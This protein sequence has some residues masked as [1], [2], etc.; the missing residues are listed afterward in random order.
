M[1]LVSAPSTSAFLAVVDNSLIALNVTLEVVQAVSEDTSDGLGKAELIAKVVAISLAGASNMSPQTE[2]K[3]ICKTAELIARISHVS[4][5]TVRLI[6][7]DDTSFRSWEIFAANVFGIFRTS[8]NLGQLGEQKLIEKL[9]KDPNATRPVYECHGEDIVY[10]GERPIIKE[11][12]EKEIRTLI[13]V[14]RGTLAIETGLRVGVPSKAKHFVVEVLPNSGPG[15]HMAARIAN[16]RAYLARRLAPP[17]PAAVGARVPGAV[18]DTS[19]DSASSRSA[20]GSALRSA[21]GSYGDCPITCMPIE[22]PSRDARF[23]THVY[24]DS[25]IRKWLA[26]NNRSPLNGLPMTVANL[27]PC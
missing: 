2:T 8:F 11:E 17:A 27:E 1:S 24:E 7:T 16:A 23:P 3:I 5:S 14:E 15:R 22:R 19:S 6:R 18:S 9:E 21:P 4:L 10:A 20:I 13:Q 25:A 26:T 12:C